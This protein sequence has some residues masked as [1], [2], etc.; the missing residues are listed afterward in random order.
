[1]RRRHSGWWVG[2]GLGVMLTLA[3][4]SVAWAALGNDG[5]GVP[6]GEREAA[7]LPPPPAPMMSD[8]A[9][10]L[11]ADSVPAGAVPWASLA[12][13]PELGGAMMQ[14]GGGGGP[15]LEYYA[16]D[17]LGSVRVVF[18]AAGAVKSRADYEPFGASVAAS[19]TGPLPREQFTGQQRD[20]EV[21]LDYFGARFYHAAHGRML[22]VDPLYVGAVSDPQRWNRYA[23]A[24]NSP[25][26]MI[27][28]DGR[29]TCSGTTSI[30]GSELGHCGDGSTGYNPANRPGVSTPTPGQFP[31]LGGGPIGSDEEWFNENYGH[32]YFPDP[33]GGVRIPRPNPSGDGGEVITGGSTS[34]PIIVVKPVPPCCTPPPIV[35]KPP[36]VGPGLAVVLI[37][38]ALAARA[39]L[40]AAAAFGMLSRANQYGIL[41]YGRL[42]NTLRGTGLHAHHLIEQRFAA[43]VGQ[44]PRQMS[45][46]AVTPAEHQVFT[47]AWRAAIP[48]GAGTANATY[49]QVMNAAKQ[50]YAQYP[51]ILSHLGI[52]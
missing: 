15:V 9:G 17:A 22:S 21:G 2:L 5:S 34:P 52:K 43:V 42:A 24:L 3:S 37:R 41:P 1:M 16:L 13:P 30:P 14:G 48:Y 50:I 39:S 51:A 46:I 20:S 47:N 31:L 36:S 18:D 27:D 10:A 32:G 11:S 6:R 49:A 44:V 19:T 26:S 35:Q 23:Y 38:V 8:G 4:P 29:T 7:H 33:N 40:A 45:A 25:T 12:P 28:P